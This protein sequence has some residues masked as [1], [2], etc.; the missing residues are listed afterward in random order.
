MCDVVATAKIYRVAH[1][2]RTVVILDK[3][4]I[5]CEKTR[6]D[7][8][9]SKANAAWRDRCSNGL[10][11]V[12]QTP[13]ARIAANSRMGSMAL[14]EFSRRLRSGIAA[15]ALLAAG[16]FFALPMADAAAQWYV[17]GQG[18]I[19]IPADS[20]LDGTGFDVDAEIDPGF[21]GLVT[22][23]H[24]YEGLFRVGGE[25]G[26]RDGEVDDVGGVSASGDV[27][28]LSAMF[29]VFLDFDVGEP[30]LK[31]FIGA[32]LGVARVSADGVNPVNGLRMDDDDTG[33]AGQL[34][35]GVAYRIAE[36]LNKL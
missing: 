7:L 19:N 33:L 20:D 29:N 10:K 4:F 34:M 26:Y 18:G 8:E 23:G 31:P 30:A 15:S 6:S 14:S 36:N 35:A 27:D 16:A 9:A 24:D 2:G 32:G 21:V 17:E 11:R 13:S 3:Q 22:I 25:F 28:V 5:F 1:P 12:S